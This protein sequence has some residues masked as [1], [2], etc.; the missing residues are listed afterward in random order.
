MAMVQTLIMIVCAAVSS[1]H[2]MVLRPWWPAVVGDIRIL[3]SEE[4]SNITAAV[5]ALPNTGRENM[6]Q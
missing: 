2:R 4:R 5:Q 6:P 1:P 3:I